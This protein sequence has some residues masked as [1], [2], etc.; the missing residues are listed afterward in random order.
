MVLSPE[1]RL[2]GGE[3]RVERLK[4]AAVELAQGFLTAHQVQSGTL[5]GAGFGQHQCALREIERGKTDLSRHCRDRRSPMEPTCDHQMENEEEMAFKAEHNAFTH[6]TEFMHDLPMGLGKRWIDCPEEKGAM[7][8]DAGDLLSND[9][10]LKRFDV[11][12]H[13]REFR[14]AIRRQSCRV[15]RAISVVEYR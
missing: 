13:I 6:P 1:C 9:L 11:D 3:V 5:L 10:A 4:P 7:Q 14:H 12:R 8:S 2:K 15:I